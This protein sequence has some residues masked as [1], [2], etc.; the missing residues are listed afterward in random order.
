MII[1]FTRFVAFRTNFVLFY[2]ERALKKYTSGNILLML[3]FKQLQKPISQGTPREK[4]KLLK[5]VEFKSA[6]EL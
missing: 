5:L 4:V 2:I 6:E 3:I 1:K